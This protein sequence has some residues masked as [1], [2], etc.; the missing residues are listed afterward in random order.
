MLAMIDVA[1][2]AP[3]GTASPCTRCS[4]VR[5]RPAPVPCTHAAP[6]PTAPPRPC[7][8]LGKSSSAK[9]EALPPSPALFT[10]AVSVRW[11]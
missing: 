1:L 11:E 8:K 10:V 6:A 2:I 5:R 4:V 7:S 3:G 9:S